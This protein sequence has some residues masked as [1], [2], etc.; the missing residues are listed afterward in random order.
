MATGLASVDP[1]KTVD[2]YDLDD[3]DAN[4]PV[5]IPYLVPALAAGIIKVTLSWKMK[6]FRS[7]ANLN[8]S[9]VAAGGA[10]T[11]SVTTSNIALT[12]TL[13]HDGGAGSWSLDDGA[14]RVVQ[15]TGFDAVADHT[16]GLTGSTTQAVTE[17]PVASIT[18]ISFDGADKTSGLGGPWTGDVVELDISSVFLKAPGLWHEIALSLS[19]LGRV[20]SLLRI[21]YTT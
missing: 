20:V 15:T 19:G 6:A 16:H 17:G 2:H 5:Y 7:T 12:H 3:G 21:Y 18:A 13:R 10:H 11:P 4:Y 9:S 1:T 14:S 8:A